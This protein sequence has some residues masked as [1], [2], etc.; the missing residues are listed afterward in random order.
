MYIITLDGREEEGAYS[1]KNEDGEQVLYIWEHEDDATRFAM[2]L[3]DR[4]YPD[5]N[6]MEIDDELIIKACELHD[7][8]Y[9]VFTP[10]DIVIPPDQNIKNDFI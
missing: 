6:V 4:D 9:I 1:V 7:Y 10:D 8:Q 3:E 2:M 5:M